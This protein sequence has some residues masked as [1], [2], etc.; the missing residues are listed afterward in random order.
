[1]TEPQYIII[2]GGGEKRTD[3]PPPSSTENHS[4][5]G[6]G[7]RRYKTGNRHVRPLCL[8]PLLS[9]P[10]FPRG[11]PNFCPAARPSV[12]KKTTIRSFLRRP[13][14]SAAREIIHVRFRVYTPPYNINYNN[15]PFDYPVSGSGHRIGTIRARI[16]Y[17]SVFFSFFFPLLFSS[18]PKL[19]AR[20][21]CTTRKIP[22]STGI[23]DSSHIRSE[24]EFW[25]L[26]SDRHY[27]VFYN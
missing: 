14:E 25:F 24:S 2:I 8:Y 10:R 12:A 27:F 19:L 18:G 22:D 23:R 3:G 5:D 7:A 1:M 21:S 11:R 20:G 6:P 13:G 15:I 26:N 17:E 9:R 4:R 16:L